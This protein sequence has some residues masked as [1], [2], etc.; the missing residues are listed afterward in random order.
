[1]T[2][3]AGLALLA[4]AAAMFAPSWCVRLRLWVGGRG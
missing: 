4:L 3:P 1:M 2:T